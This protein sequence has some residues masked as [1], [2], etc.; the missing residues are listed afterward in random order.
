MKQVYNFSRQYHHSCEQ[1]LALIIL[2]LQKIDG[3]ESSD[4]NVQ[5]LRSQMGIV[6]QEPVL[7]DCS[8]AENIAYGDNSRKVEMSEVIQAAKEANIHNFITEL[9]NVSIIHYIK[10]Q[11]CYNVSMI[12][13][14][15]F[16]MCYNGEY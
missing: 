11:M 13:N 12:H 8:I 7:F 15:K 3:I 16:Q 5:Y 4:Y 14:I 2:L 6:S 9:P 10:F 1:P